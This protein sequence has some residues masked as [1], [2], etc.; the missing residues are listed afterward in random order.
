M[1]MSGRNA[2]RGKKDALKLKSRK[3]KWMKKPG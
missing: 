1:K 3:K 2:K